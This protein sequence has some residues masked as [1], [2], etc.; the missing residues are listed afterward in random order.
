MATNTERPQYTLL[1]TV[2]GVEIRHYEPMIVATTQRGGFQQLAN[3]IFGGNSDR[4]R[5]AMTAPVANTITEQGWATAFMM[6]SQY[7]LSDLPEPDSEEVALQKIPAR[8]MAVIQFSGWAN[9]DSITRHQQLLQ[10][11]IERHQWPVDGAMIVNQYDDPWTPAEA[12]TNEIQYPL[13]DWNEESVQRL[14]LH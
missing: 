10:A 2:D 4:Q 11:V 12:R 8:T 5:I 1:A 3:Y 6:P 13:S 14:T 7:R 9:R